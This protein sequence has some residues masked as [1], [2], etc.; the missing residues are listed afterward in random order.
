MDRTNE[1]GGL[2]ELWDVPKPEKKADKGTMAVDLEN[3]SPE[4]IKKLFKSSPYCVYAVEL[5]EQGDDYIDVSIRSTIVDRVFFL[6][7]VPLVGTVYSS[8]MHIGLAYVNFFGEVVVNVVRN[9]DFI[10]IITEKSR[11]VKEA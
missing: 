3:A 4:M 5:E 6:K 9:K 10:Y 7:K 1:L 8:V 11:V 2:G